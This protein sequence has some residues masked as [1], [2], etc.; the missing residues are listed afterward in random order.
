MG[1]DEE[2]GNDRF[3]GMKREEM[4]DL[5]G[6]SKREEMTDREGGRKKRGGRRAICSNSQRWSFH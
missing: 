6:E 3:G 5:E 4:T 2:G 1:R